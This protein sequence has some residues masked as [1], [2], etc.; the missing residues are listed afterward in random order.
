[1]IGRRRSFF[2][3]AW[4]PGAAPRALVVA[5]VLVGVLTLHPTPFWRGVAVVAAL[6]GS[7]L[8]RSLGA[9]AGAACLPFGLLLSEPAPERT[10]LAVLL[11]HAIH[12]LGSLSLT[13]PAVSRLT[14]ASL[15]PTARRFLVVQLVAQPLSLG[16]WLLAPTG[17]ERGAAWL[18]PAAAVVLLAA[19]VGAWLALRRGRGAVTSAAGTASEGAD[20]G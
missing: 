15:W 8:P 14:L 1:M 18:A 2:V 10:A 17:V 5:L 9:W 19:V 13:V 11:V 4:V 3:G 16:V 20:Q 6:V 7:V 12:V